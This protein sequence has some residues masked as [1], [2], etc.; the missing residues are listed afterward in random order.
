VRVNSV[1]PGFVDTPILGETDRQMLAEVTP[2]GRV[3]APEELAG[4]M[5]FL[6]SDDASFVTGAEFVVDGGYTAR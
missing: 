5:V 4:V 6:A 1:H 2:M 3:A